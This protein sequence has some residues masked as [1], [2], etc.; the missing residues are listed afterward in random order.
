LATSQRAG[1]WEKTVAALNLGGQF[2][3][4]ILLCISRFRCSGMLASG[5][6]SVRFRP[7]LTVSHAELATAVDEVRAALG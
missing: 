6:D 7:A 2:M 5:E 1:D 4:D 3:I